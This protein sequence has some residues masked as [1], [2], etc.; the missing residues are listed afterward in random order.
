MHE[1]INAQMHKWLG[2]RVFVHS[3]IRALMHLSHVLQKIQYAPRV[4]DATAVTAAAA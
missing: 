2:I 4:T 1:R 3:C